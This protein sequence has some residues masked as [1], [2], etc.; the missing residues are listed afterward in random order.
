MTYL[1]QLFSISESVA[2]WQDTSTRS[3][4]KCGS[5]FIRKSHWFFLINFLVL[6]ES[7]W[8][9]QSQDSQGES[10]ETSHWVAAR[11][12]FQTSSGVSRLIWSFHLMSVNSL[13]HSKCCY[14]LCT[15][16][17]MYFYYGR[18]I[19]K[20]PRKIYLK[21]SSVSHLSDVILPGVIILIVS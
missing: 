1:C 14:L 13:R 17:Y 6:A 15:V 4:Q 16:F 19:W 11:L 18:Y 10:S 21:F 3:E 9:I 5:N 7:C 2:S 12:I 20:P 8:K